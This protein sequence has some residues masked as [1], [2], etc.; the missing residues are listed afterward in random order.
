MLAYAQQG[1]FHVEYRYRPGPLCRWLI[2]RSFRMV[3]H[4]R[5][6]YVALSGSREAG[7]DVMRCGLLVLCIAFQPFLASNPAS[8][9]D[10]P[11]TSCDT[12]AASP[13][14]PQRQTT[15]VTAV[16]PALAI[17][18][19]SSA[20]TTYPASPRLSFQLGRAYYAAR[21]FR[22]AAALFLRAAE[23][24]YAAAETALGDAFQ[25]G[26]GVSQSYS[27]AMHWY[28]KAARQGFAIAQNSLGALYEQGLGSPRDIIVAID[29]Y[30]KAAKQGDSSA[31]ANLTRLGANAFANTK[32]E[33]PSAPPAPA[34]KPPPSPV[35]PS[36]VN[37]ES[38]DGS[39]D[40]QASAQTAYMRPAFLSEHFNGFTVKQ[41]LRWFLV[42]WLSL[43][44]IL[45]FP[46]LTRKIPILYKRMNFLLSSIVFIPPVMWALL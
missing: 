8:A 17:S 11:L 5:G 3:G 12:Y 7:Q 42:I 45:L 20:L 6:C 2:P 40:S 43:S 10:I 15:G 22:E 14:D 31:Q 4:G 35:R 1:A 18:A 32:L 46:A 38:P 16:N 44:F 24:G 36:V 34:S 37:L 39:A 27:D 41:W 30:R 19:C 25:Y 26:T 28:S 29:W 9:Q 23:E 13:F 21:N 33:S